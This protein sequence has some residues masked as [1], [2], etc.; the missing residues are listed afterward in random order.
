[1]AAVADDLVIDER[2]AILS[3]GAARLEGAY[4]ASSEGSELVLP[5]GS[6]VT[7]TLQAP[8]TVELALDEI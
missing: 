8:A 7:F 5:A 6:H 4:E 1:M 3:G 2:V